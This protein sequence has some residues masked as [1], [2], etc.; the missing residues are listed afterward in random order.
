MAWFLCSIILSY[1][2]T[3]FAIGADGH[4]SPFK[5]LKP[6]QKFWG[7]GAWGRR[8]FFKRVPPPQSI[9]VSHMLRRRRRA[10]GVRATICTCSGQQRAACAEGVEVTP[11]AGSAVEQGGGQAQIVG[12]RVTAEIFGV[13]GGPC[14]LV[15]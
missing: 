6:E 10:P 9:F 8:P 13:Q 1:L 12:L 4:G 3:L 15:A 2:S 11:H 7:V 5:S 14:G